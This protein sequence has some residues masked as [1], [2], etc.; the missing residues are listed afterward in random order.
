MKTD[1]DKELFE[2]I[3]NVYKMMKKNYSLFKE[4][5]LSMVQLHGLIYIFE[6]PRCTLKELA[7]KFSISNPS[8]NDLVNRLVNSNLVKREED[9]QD[10]RLVHLSLTNK[11][12]KVLDGILKR[13]KQCFSSLIEK[14]S[15][16]EKKQLLLILRK[17]TN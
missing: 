10:R 14:L 4:N 3:F 17:I 6:N 9:K 16:E 12:K 11:G 1:I 8:A 7:E 15:R 2:L 5:N 13:K